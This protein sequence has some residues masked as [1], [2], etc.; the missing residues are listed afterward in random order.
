MKQEPLSCP[1]TWLA[2]W[3]KGSVQKR[4]GGEY[5]LAAS[6]RNRRPNLLLLLSTHSQERSGARRKAARVSRTGRQA[7]RRLAGQAS[8]QRPFVNHTHTHTHS[9]KIGQLAREY[10]YYFD[11]LRAPRLETVLVVK[12]C[13][14]LHST[15]R[16]RSQIFFFFF[17][18]F[19]LTSWFAFY[20]SDL[21]SWLKKFFSTTSVVQASFTVPPPPSVPSPMLP[22]A[23]VMVLLRRRRGTACCPHES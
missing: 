2:R 6:N 23:G 13:W 7:G 11:P 3:C 8:E 4:V 16:C 22:F 15:R 10:F 9:Q 19:F 18:S 14:Y 5:D 1:L 12:S 20:S 21:S 17:S